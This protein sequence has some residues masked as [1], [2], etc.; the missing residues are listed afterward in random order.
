M[1]PFINIHFFTN[2]VL[3]PNMFLF[4]YTLHL[5]PICLVN[6]TSSA[7][8]RPMMHI[9]GSLALGNESYHEKYM[10]DVTFIKI[11]SR[12]TASS[13]WELIVHKWG[14]NYSTLQYY[15]LIHSLN[16]RSTEWATYNFYCSFL[17]TMCPCLSC[18]SNKTKL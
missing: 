5:T 14:C 3:H 16:I 15:D 4:T 7:E 6:S 1:F 9:R 17:T 18:C 2:F 11:I 12:K 8:V 10:T 13:S